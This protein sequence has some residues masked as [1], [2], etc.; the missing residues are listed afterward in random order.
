MEKEG[1][2]HIPSL[3]GT[4]EENTNAH[5]V[6][7]ASPLG[8]IVLQYVPE[9]TFKKNKNKNKTKQKNPHFSEHTESTSETH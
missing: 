2:V 8:A 9:R 1:H 6:A 5:L 3:P 4:A 7:D